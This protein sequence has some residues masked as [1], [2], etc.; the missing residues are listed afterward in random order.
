MAELINLEN[1][2]PKAHPLK[3]ELQ[4]YGF[5]T[6]MLAKYLG[7]SYQHTCNI[8]NGLNPLSSKYDEKVN[9]LVFTLEV[10]SKPE[11]EPETEKENN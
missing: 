4:K 10:K 2:K 1:L 9:D 3:A 8:L 5:T 7:M 6:G 11:T